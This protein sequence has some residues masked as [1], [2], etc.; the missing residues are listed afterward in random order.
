MG[1]DA[2]SSVEVDY[3]RQPA[4]I[5]NEDQHLAFTNEAKSIIN[6]AGT[7]DGNFDFG[8]LDCSRC[9]RMLEKATGE[10]CYGADWDAAKVKELRKNANWK[11]YR[12]KEHK[13]AYLSAKKFLELCA[14]FDLSI[15]FSW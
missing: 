1:W 6:Q 15:S 10:S 3:T 11:F 2:H 4:R 7:V 12:S 13:W 8:G 14:K 9:A 5:K